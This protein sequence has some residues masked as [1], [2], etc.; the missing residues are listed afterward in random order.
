MKY[1]FDTIINR[2]NSFSY[3][4]DIKDNELPMWVADMD[5]Q[6]A[7][8]VINRL[9][10]RVNHGIFGYSI[11]PDVW[12][13]TYI[14]WWKNNHNFKIEKDWLIFTS[15]VVA[16]ISSIVRRLTLPGEKVLIQT[17]VYNIF[18]NSIINNGRFVVENELVYDGNS[19]SINFE[20]LEKKLSQPQV[21]LMILCNPHNPVGKIWSKD[22]LAKI[23]KLCHKYDVK[24]ISD[25]VHCDITDPNVSYIPFA[26][27]SKECK[28]IS[29]SCFS[30]SKAFNLAG[31][32]SAA[33]C[34]PNENLRNRVDRG[35]N[36]DE[37]AEPNAFAIVSTIAAYNEGR[38]WLKEL[39]EYIYTNKQIVK[40]FIN[41]NIQDIKLVPS[42]AT[43]LLWIDCSKLDCDSDKLASFIREK[44]GLYL[45]DGL[46]YGHA[47]RNF[48]RMNIAC[49]KTVLKDGLN[50]LKKGIE[51][52]LENK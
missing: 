30:P 4:W 11:I 17:P 48:L 34:I 14:N 39:N 42:N 18:F 13:D 44:T 16:S 20:D 35:L 51:L 32:H 5:F 19:Y 15:G 2:R 45:A 38:Q 22:E 27:V 8:Q 50:R 6:T 47:G 24:V 21:K 49:S 28:E 1:D 40:E 29:V 23:G 31:M 36:N 26:S 3:K 10:E 7:P 25:E 12:Y 41:N 37:V 43:Y 46:E 9:S 33:V 52:F